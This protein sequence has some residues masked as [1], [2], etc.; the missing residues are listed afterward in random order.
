[1]DPAVLDPTQVAKP[2]K[3]AKPPA[4]TDD[5][6]KPFLLKLPPEYRDALL[7]AKKKTGREM[8]VSG[9]IALEMYFRAIGVP[10]TP[11]WSEIDP[12]GGTASRA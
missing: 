7:V 10:F 5:A 9:Q 11:N 8:T 6:E 2:K 12:P 4:K 3:P 1:M